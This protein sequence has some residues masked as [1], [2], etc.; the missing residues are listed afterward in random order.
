MIQKDA[1]LIVG[2]SDNPNRYAYLAADS[3][4]RHKYKIE[5]IGK[6][7]KRVFGKTIETDRKHYENIDTVTLYVGPHNQT[8]LYDY[9]V[10][11]KP[12]RVIFNPG[13]ENEEFM[14][15]LRENEIDVEVA[16]TLVMLH[17][18]QY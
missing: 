13:T 3:L 17:T 12:R 10:S 5:L 6:R 14:R 11:L 1:T 8:E 2:A 7:A 4:I 18:R 16:C 15:I 9:I